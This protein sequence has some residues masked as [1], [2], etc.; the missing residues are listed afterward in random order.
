MKRPERT[1]PEVIVGR[2]VLIHLLNED[3]SATVLTWKL[4]RAFPAGY[5]FSNL[6]ARGQEPL[7][8]MLEL[9]YERLEME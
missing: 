2:T 1:A 3:R 7:L 4:L 8:E 5:T 9:A 6:D